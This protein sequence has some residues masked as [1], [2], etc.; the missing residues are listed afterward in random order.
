MARLGIEQMESKTI[1]KPSKGSNQ[2]FD[3]VTTS[4][5]SPPTM[6]IVPSSDSPKN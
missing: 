2:A 3:H 1:M 4:R 5:E 6:S